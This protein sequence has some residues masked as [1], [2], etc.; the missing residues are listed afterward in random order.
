MTGDIREETLIEEIADERLFSSKVAA[1]DVIATPRMGGWNALPVGARVELYPYKVFQGMLSAYG[2]P[3]FSDERI[4]E[5]ACMFKRPSDDGNVSD[6]EE[7][8]GNDGNTIV[9]GV[10]CE[11]IRR[12]WQIKCLLTI[13]TTAPS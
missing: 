10:D 4:V 13:P 2:I 3:C 6:E 11:S 12:G 7:G 8:D 9:V 5:A 1:K